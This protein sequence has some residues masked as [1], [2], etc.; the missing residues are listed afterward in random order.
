MRVTANAGE[1][2]FFLSS[3]THSVM[4]TLS[5]IE[6]DFYESSLYKI[7]RRMIIAR[8]STIGI[9]IFYSLRFI[10]HCKQFVLF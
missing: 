6:K 1:N 10:C 8:N 4:M 7:V 2:D 5:A 9:F 3:P